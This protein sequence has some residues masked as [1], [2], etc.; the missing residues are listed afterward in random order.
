MQVPIPVLTVQL[1]FNVDAMWFEA[2][3]TFWEKKR[4]HARWFTHAVCVSEDMWIALHRQYIIIILPAPDRDWDGA[5][6]CHAKPLTAAA[7]SAWDR[8]M[9]SAFKD[10]DDQTTQSYR[11]IVIGIWSIGAPMLEDEPSA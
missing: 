7:S 4:E 2:I 8:F 9:R 10:T 11:P 3:Y 1:T 5:A 6:A